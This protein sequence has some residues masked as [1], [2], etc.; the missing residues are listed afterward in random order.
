MA[1]SRIPV[2][3][4]LGQDPAKMGQAGRAAISPPPESGISTAALSLMSAILD[5]PHIG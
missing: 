4:H 3:R 2:F 1:T 5:G